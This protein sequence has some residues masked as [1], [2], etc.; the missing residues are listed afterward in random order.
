MNMLKIKSEMWWIGVPG[1]NMF[2]MVATNLTAAE[3]ILK[4]LEL[5]IRDWKNSERVKDKKSESIY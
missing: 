3:L 2:V 1:S 5:V 4:G